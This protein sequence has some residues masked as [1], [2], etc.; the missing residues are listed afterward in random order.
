MGCTE[1]RGLLTELAVLLSEGSLFR[2]V[3]AA[4]FLPVES[5]CCLAAAWLLLDFAEESGYY[6]CQLS[7]FA[8]NVDQEKPFFPM[9]FACR[10]A[11]KL[12]L[13]F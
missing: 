2:L 1:K 6:R 9:P 4:S 12:G 7:C 10:T 8:T 13:W 11:A 3:Q 5:L